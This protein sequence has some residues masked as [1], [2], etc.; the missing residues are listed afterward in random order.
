[1]PEYNDDGT[2]LGDVENQKKTRRNCETEDGLGC[3]R[4]C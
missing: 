3:L 1:M 2:K 4:R